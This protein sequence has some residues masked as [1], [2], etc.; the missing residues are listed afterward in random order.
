MSW[1]AI[2]VGHL[3]SIFAI[4]DLRMG[5]VLWGPL[6]V[7]GAVMVTATFWGQFFVSARLREVVSRCV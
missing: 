2:V 4:L 7:A 5:T 6:K 3:W 1:R